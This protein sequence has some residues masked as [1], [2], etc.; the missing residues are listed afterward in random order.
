MYRRSRRSHSKDIKSSK[1]SRDSRN[2]IVV[3]AVR[4]VRI[5]ERV[6]VIKATG[7]KIRRIIVVRMRIAKEIII[8]GEG[9]RQEE[10]EW[11]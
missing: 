5:G 7:I 6:I 9:K 10:R 11:S 1:S 8:E 3:T 2:S 4:I